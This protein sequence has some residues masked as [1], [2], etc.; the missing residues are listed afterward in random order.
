M[1]DTADG[2][3][4]MARAAAGNPALG[5]LWRLSSVSRQNGHREGHRYRSAA[6]GDFSND[7]NEKKD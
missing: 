4:A 3:T 2:S 5:A 7:K 6:P 1:A